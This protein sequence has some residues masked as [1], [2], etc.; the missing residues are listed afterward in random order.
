MT[1]QVSSL[2]AALKITQ[3][4]TVAQTALAAGLPN[5]GEHPSRAVIQ[6]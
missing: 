5:S 2:E 1:L 4:K 6:D 3:S